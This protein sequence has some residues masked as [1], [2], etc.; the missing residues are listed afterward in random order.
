MIELKHFKPEEFDG[1][2][3]MDEYFLQWLDTVRALADVPFYITSDWRSVL[4][5]RRVGGHPASLHVK[6]RAVD[7]ATPGSRARD[8][9]KYYEELFDIA[10]AI[11]SN[12]EGTVQFEIVKGPTDWHIHL[13]L[14]DDDWT[15][16][17]KLIVATD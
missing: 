15:G 1:P 5:N 13:G 14:Y 4:N 7:F 6:G 16:P 2:E 8:A 3:Q 9:Q 11:F 17:D 12:Y 10:Y